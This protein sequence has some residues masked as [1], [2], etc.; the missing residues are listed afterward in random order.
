MKNLK[1]TPF[2]LINA[3]ILTILAYLVFSECFLQL[4]TITTRKLIEYSFKKMLVKVALTLTV[5]KICRSK[6]GGIVADLAGNRKRH[7]F[8]EAYIVGMFSSFRK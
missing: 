7:Y 5:F 4:I 6:V 3:L 8:N 1:N 2:V